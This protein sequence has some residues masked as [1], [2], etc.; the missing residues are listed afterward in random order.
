MK[1]DTVDSIKLPDR[2]YRI[3][4][5]FI[6]GFFVAFSGSLVYYFMSGDA[7]AVKLVG[8]TFGGWLGTILGFYFG[9][10]PVE[11]FKKELKEERK[12]ANDLTDYLREKSDQMWRKLEPKEADNGE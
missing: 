1:N 7:E 3:A 4:L 2:Q 9:Q 10:K 11:D 12:R 8:T 5:V 6:L